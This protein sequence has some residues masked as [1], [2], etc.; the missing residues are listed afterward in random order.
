MPVENYCATFDIGVCELGRICGRL[1]P[2]RSSNGR[3]R[4][5]EEGLGRK[6]VES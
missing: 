4:I 2:F 3:G 6:C 5:G 1:G